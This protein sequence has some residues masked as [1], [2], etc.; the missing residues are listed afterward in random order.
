MTTICQV[1]HDTQ[2]EA[3]LDMRSWKQ[4]IRYRSCGCMALPSPFQVRN[5][6]LLWAAENFTITVKIR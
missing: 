6:L 1:L 5:M 3:L 2:R 4:T